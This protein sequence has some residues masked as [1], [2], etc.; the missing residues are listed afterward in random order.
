MCEETKALPWC[1]ILSGQTGPG[2]IKKNKL[3]VFN[4]PEAGMSNSFQK[5]PD[6]P[7]AAQ[8]A[9]L[10]L[11]ASTTSSDTLN[12]HLALSSLQVPAHC[13]KLYTN[14]LT[15]VHLSSPLDPERLVANPD[16]N[17]RLPADPQTAADAGRK[18]RNVT[19]V[20]FRQQLKALH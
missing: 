19:C 7:Q 5:S 10:H 20:C 1:R 4:N 14:Q 9:A 11:S 18:H 8:S 12:K 2:F 16:M 17:I 13:L 15:S 6:S 3:L